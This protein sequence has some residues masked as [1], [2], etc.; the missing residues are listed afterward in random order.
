MYLV[1][2][3]RAGDPTVVV[4]WRDVQVKGIGL[5]CL[6]SAEFAGLRMFVS[7]WYCSLLQSAMY[8]G[9]STLNE[10]HFL[11]CEGPP[12]TCPA[13]LSVCIWF[14]VLLNPVYG[15]IRFPIDFQYRYYEAIYVYALAQ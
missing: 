14:L 2:D 13:F 11:Y 10:V 9:V 4:L 6:L 12:C 5:F 7:E 3:G 15:L 8:A 1:L